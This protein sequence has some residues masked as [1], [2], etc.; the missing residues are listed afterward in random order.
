MDILTT[1]LNPGVL[2]FIL[3]LI[4]IL[5]NSN[6]SIPESVVKF[7]SIYLMLS[8]GFKGGVSLHGT[9]ILGDGLMIIGIIIAMS[10]FVP[11]YSYFLLKKKLGVADACAIG[12]T[13]G[14]NSTLTYIT[15]AG[16]LTSIGVAYDGYMTVA[17][18]V[19]E[20]PAIILSIVMAQLSLK[21]PGRRSTKAVVKEAI[22]D[23]TLIV[24][25]GSMVIG[26]L[27]TALGTEKS[28]LA[29]F[30]SGDMF[31]GM[32]VF[33]L[34]YMGTVVG[35]KIKE[36]ESFPMILVVFSIVAPIV[37]GVIAILIS[38][39]CGFDHG[40]AFLLTILCASASYIVAP[41]ILKDTLPEANPAK[42]LTMSMGITFPLNIVIGI[43]VY[44]WAVQKFV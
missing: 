9:S 41:A 39:A 25:V 29:T 35:K 23:G 19:M 14:S 32:L 13:Y 16:F 22:T 11:I 21:G 20:T 7:V 12:A 31:T 44:W 34:L 24:L 28:P 38:K 10:A 17:L 5:V 18:V 27:L 6:L 43:P 36:I 33:F 3:G 15:A 4:A 42:Y 26:Y 2:F 1:L 8:I 30:I 40:D 37:N